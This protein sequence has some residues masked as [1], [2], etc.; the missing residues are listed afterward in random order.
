ME[1]YAI[2]GGRRL[3]GEVRVHGAKHS[4]LQGSL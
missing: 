3:T 2:K 1:Y 4:V